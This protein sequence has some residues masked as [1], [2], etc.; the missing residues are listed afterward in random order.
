MYGT[1]NTKGKG[2]AYEQCTLVGNVASHRGIANNSG[3]IL[4]VNS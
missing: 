1:C 4:E 2:I 3:S